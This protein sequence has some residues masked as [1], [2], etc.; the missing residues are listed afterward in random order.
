MSLDR[1]HFVTAKKVFVNCHSLQYHI[2]WQNRK[3]SLKTRDTVHKSMM[4]KSG[5]LG[6]WHTPFYK[7]LHGGQ[8]FQHI[9]TIRMLTVYFLLVQID[10]AQPIAPFLKSTE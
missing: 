5:A 2:K 6:K 8:S 9:G 4:R 10:P 1:Y 7:C 3:L